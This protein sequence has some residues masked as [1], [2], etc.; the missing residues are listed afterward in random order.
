MDEFSGVHI[1]PHYLYDQVDLATASV[2]DRVAILEDRLRGYLTVPCGLLLNVYEHSIFIVLMAVLS[3]VEL[4]ETL[5]TGK[6][7]RPDPEAA[8]KSGLMRVLKQA[9]HFGKVPGAETLPLDNALHEIYVQVRCGL[10]HLGTTR[11]KVFIDP[12]LGSP[13]MV[14]YDRMGTT[15]DQIVL[16]PRRLVVSLD[17]FISEY[18]TQLRN[19][20]NRELRE[21]FE[22][23][24]GVLGSD[25]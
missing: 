3:C 5:Y 23:G 2:D 11:S 17:T 7:T 19:P 13:V 4:I 10:M 1:S 18:C 15:V 21:T 8:F 12:S 24:W 6:S 25:N 22:R 9:Q 16:N 20:R 14:K